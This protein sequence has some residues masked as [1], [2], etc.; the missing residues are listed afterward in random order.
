MDGLDVYID[1]YSKP[2]PLPEEWLGKLNQLARLGDYPARE[3]ERAKQAEKDAEA[4][5]IEEKTE[6]PQSVEE[7]KVAASAQP[8]QEDETPPEV[9]TA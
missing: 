4:A 9:G 3:A 6:E 7:P 8:P 1:D 5:R 2:D